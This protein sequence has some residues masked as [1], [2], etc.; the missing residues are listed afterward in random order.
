MHGG[1]L[2]TLSEEHEKCSELCSGVDSEAQP[3]TCRRWL[4]HNAHR[5]SHYTETTE[6]YMQRTAAIFYFHSQRFFN[7]NR[8]EGSICFW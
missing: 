6:K 7:E 5:I 1:R 2:Q 8:L 4:A 3:V